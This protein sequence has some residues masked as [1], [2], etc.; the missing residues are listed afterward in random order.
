[1]LYALNFH[2][3]LIEEEGITVT[4]MPAA[5]SL[6]A[7][8]AEFDTPQSNGLVTHRDSALGHEIFDITSTQINA[9]IEPER[10]ACP[11]GTL[12]GLADAGLTCLP[13]FSLLKQS[14][15]RVPFLSIELPYE[16]PRADPYHCF[17]AFL[18]PWQGNARNYDTVACRSPLGGG[19]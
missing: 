19:T 9:V 12:P 5:K 11:W 1:V 2:E 7:L 6:G 16:V 13:S 8:R 18:E 4:L 10:E 17:S 3:N 15:W 14:Y